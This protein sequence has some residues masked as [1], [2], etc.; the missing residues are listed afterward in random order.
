MSEAAAKEYQKATDRRRVLETA[1]SPAPSRLATLSEYKVLHMG[2][3]IDD[4]WVGELTLINEDQPA[5]IDTQF[6]AAHRRKPI[7]TEPCAT[8]DDLLEAI[9]TECP[10]DVPTLPD[11]KEVLAE[12]QLAA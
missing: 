1:L 12:R 10:E 2:F 8:I 7:V 6:R 9:A 3:T 5:V 4:N 11:Y